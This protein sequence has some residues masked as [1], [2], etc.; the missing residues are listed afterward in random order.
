MTTKAGDRLYLELNGKRGCDWRSA[1]VS[2]PSALEIAGKPSRVVVA[3]RN[4]HG[5]DGKIASDAIAADFVARIAALKKLCYKVTVD[6]K[7]GYAVD[8]VPATDKSANLT[9]TLD[10]N[11]NVK[12]SGKIGGTSVSGASTLNVDDGDYYT[13]GDA[14]A[15]LGKTEALYFA[16]GF[17]R[18]ADGTPSPGLRIDHVAE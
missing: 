2:S 15:P 18:N 16:L 8:S 11:G 14:T 3:W 10:A 6:A 13:I 1:R 7:A 4:E 9:V 12:Y 17:D 5:K